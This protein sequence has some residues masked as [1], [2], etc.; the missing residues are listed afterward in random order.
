MEIASSVKVNTAES[1]RVLN[2][3]TFA[4]LRRQRAK[5]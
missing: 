1:F 5:R 3:V 4:S 2:I